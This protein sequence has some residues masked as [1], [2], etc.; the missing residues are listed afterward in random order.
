MVR[1]SLPILAVVWL[2][3]CG[4][5]DAMP[6]QVEIIGEVQTWENTR[7]SLSAI[8]K[9]ETLEPCRV[10]VEFSSDQ[11][12]TQRTGLSARGTEHQI[13]VVGMRSQTTY[14][15]QPVI[16]TDAGHES[17]GEKSDF[18]T[19]SLPE[20]IPELEVVTHEADLVQPGVTIFGPSGM[21]SEGNETWP[22]YLGVDQSGEVVW[23]YEDANGDPRR[24]ADRDA[25]MLPDGNLLLTV[26][27]G[28]RVITIGGETVAEATGHFHHDGVA[29]P[30][31]GYITLTQQTQE[32]DV[33]DLGGRVRVRG[34]VIVELDEQGQV[35]WTWSLFDH[36]DTTRFPTPL[37]KN[38]DENGIYDWT[39]SNAVV[40][41]DQDQSI[42]LSIRHQNWVIKIDRTTGLLRWRFGL[43]GDFQL[44]NLDPAEGQ[45]WFFSQHAPQPGPDDT[46]LI[47]DNGND[48]PTTP[49]PRQKFSR[50]VMYRLD[51]DGLLAEQIWQFQ[52]EA[53]TGAVGDA[54]FLDNGNVLVCAGRPPDT[55]PATVT[56]V[57]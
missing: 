13:T 11:T 19:G 28:L 17:L 40:Y 46:M 42:L 50:A 5:D 6:P 41:A 9:L 18:T 20:G 54:D 33:P 14:E 52:T 53:F 31:G 57:T 12:S 47:Y 51:Q 16:L 38:R 29:L 3:G 39:H 22:L 30:D 45:D 49:Q 10:Q 23:Y 35:S 25:K 56:E 24:H 55:H 48:R 27:S 15:L 26:A 32:L 34:D 2:T 44:A 1:Q 8:V 43:D 21:G 4:T 37:S 36:L 7:N